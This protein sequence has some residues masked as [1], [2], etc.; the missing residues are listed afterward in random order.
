MVAVCCMKS[1]PEIKLDV[2][3]Q[4]INATLWISAVTC[5]II[6][7]ERLS[8][9]RVCRIQKNSDQLWFWA[10][11]NKAHSLTL[12]RALIE[13]LGNSKFQPQRVIG[14]YYMTSFAFVT[15]FKVFNFLCCKSASMKWPY[16]ISHQSRV[17][18][19]PKNLY[20]KT[21]NSQGGMGRLFWMYLDDWKYSR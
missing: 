12:Y 3:R 19:L 2:P 14:G 8:R 6:V 18:H 4:L 7:L 9:H 15:F 10:F 21:I 11:Q 5:C 13:I 16:M 20:I 1:D 17:K